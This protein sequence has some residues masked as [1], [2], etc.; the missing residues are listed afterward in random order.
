MQCEG[1][2]LQVGGRVHL[3]VSVVNRGLEYGQ[4]PLL[5]HYLDLVQREAH[6]RSGLFDVQLTDVPQAANRAAA[7]HGEEQP[8]SR[9]ARRRC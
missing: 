9:R 3:M 6:H 4:Y 5:R 8:A 1:A 7:G 2:P